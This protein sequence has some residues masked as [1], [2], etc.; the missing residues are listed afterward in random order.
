MAI[1]K[2]EL[3]NRVWGYKSYLV[4]KT[5]DSHIFRLQQKLEKDPSNP[6]H[7]RTVHSVDYKFVA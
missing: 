1:K 3:L 2:D 7:F 4:T 6:A 5:V